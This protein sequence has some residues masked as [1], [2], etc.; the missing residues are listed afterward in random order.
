MGEAGTAAGGGDKAGDAEPGL[1]SSDGGS[2]NRRASWH[3]QYSEKKYVD[4]VIVS[5]HTSHCMRR[6]LE[7]ARSKALVV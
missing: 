6:V 3:V 4:T 2:C 1:G 7:R 5:F